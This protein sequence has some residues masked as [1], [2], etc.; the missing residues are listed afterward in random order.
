MKKTA[1]KFALSFALLILGFSLPA[2]CQAGPSQVVAL[3]NTATSSDL[4]ENPSVLK[5]SVAINISSATTTELV[6]TVAGKTV[7]VCS[8]YSTVAG[9]A[10]SLIFK[11]GTKVSTACDTGA[12]SLTGTFLPPTSTTF[13]LS[14][15]SLLFQGASGGE[16]CLTTTGTGSPSFQGV[17]TYV[18]K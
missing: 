8:F 4:C 7:S 13:N 15:H 18:Q 2:F 5:S 1:I 10:P 14:G 6:A 17:M 16:I 9:T 12:A 11:T 3:Y